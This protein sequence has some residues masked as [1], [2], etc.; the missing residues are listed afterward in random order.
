VV[1]VAEREA[2]GE[3]IIE[4]EA[5]GECSIERRLVSLKLPHFVAD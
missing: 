3:C 5:G 4:R 2:G 1:S